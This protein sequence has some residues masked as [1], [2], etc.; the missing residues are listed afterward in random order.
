MRHCFKLLLNWGLFVKLLAT[1]EMSHHSADQTD[2]PRLPIADARPPII[3][4]EHT[5]VSTYIIISGYRNAIARVFIKIN[6]FHTFRAACAVFFRGSSSVS[7]HT[8][9]CA[10]SPV[11]VGTP[12]SKNALFS[13]LLGMCGRENFANV[14]PYARQNGVIIESLQ[15]STRGFPLKEH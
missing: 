2:S 4:H 3:N 9:F 15:R 14:S 8:Q 13:I 1:I 5:I 11:P 12:T 10:D 6:S 7:L